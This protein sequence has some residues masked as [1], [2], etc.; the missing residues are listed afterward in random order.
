MADEYIKGYRPQAERPRE[1][2]LAMDYL[3]QTPRA[4]KLLKVL[5]STEGKNC[6]ARTEEF[7]GEV[8]QTDREAQLACSS[9]P[10]LK[11]CG[12]YRDEAHPA[13]GTWG[14]TVKGRNLQAAMQDDARLSTKGDT[15]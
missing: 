15:K 4:A 12:E 10:A 11:I 5:W 14:S 8:L 7:S 1:R 3:Q 13:W 9:C 2:Q 6:E